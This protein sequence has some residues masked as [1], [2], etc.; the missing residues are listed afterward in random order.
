MPESR[1]RSR[2]GSSQVRGLCICIPLPNLFPPA[3]PLSSYKRKDD[4]VALAGALGLTTE[5]TV[6]E[7]TALIKSHLSDK[8]SIELD[9]RFAGLFLQNKRRRV[10]N[11]SIKP[12]STD[13]VP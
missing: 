5:G 10:D 8:P 3:D 9:P 4:V 6:N 1:R 2:H 12:L 11:S 13:V 7:L